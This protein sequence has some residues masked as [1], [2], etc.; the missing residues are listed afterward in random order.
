VL[1]AES[2]ACSSRRYESG[3]SVSTGSFN[4]TGTSGR[5]ARPF[6]AILSLNL[7]VGHPPSPASGT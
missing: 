3:G 6:S 1:P 5:L 4:P 7:W 2:I